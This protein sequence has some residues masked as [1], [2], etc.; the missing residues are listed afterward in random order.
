MAGIGF[1]LRKLTRKGNIGGFVEAYFHA[2]FASSGPW[3]LTILTVWAFFIVG[4]YWRLSEYVEEF[5]VV[6]L[7][8]FSSS[9]V[10]T[11]PVIMLTTRYLADDFFKMDITKV[12]SL[13]IGTLSTQLIVSFPIAFCFYFFYADM[14]LEMSLLA[15]I[16]F[17]LI[18]GIWL[19]MIF[20]S[21]I[22]YYSAITFSFVT[23]MGLGVLLA[24]L[25]SGLF[26]PPGMLFGFNCGLAF[27]LSSFLAVILAEYT[28]N[29][30]NIFDFNHFWKKHWIVALS[31][32][33]YN[34]GIWID[35][36]IMW[37]SPERRVLPNNLIIYP[38]YDMAMF[39]AYLTIIPAMGLFL[40]HQETSFFEVYVRYYR[41]IMQHDPLNK[42]QRSHKDI[43][44]NLMMNGR[45]VLILQ[46]TICVFTLFL[47]PEIMNILG[48]NLVQISVFRF[49]VL[50]VTF[51]IISLFL[52]ITLSYFD[53]KRDVLIIAAT[54]LI[55]N[56][57][58]T[59]LSLN[60][61]FAYYGYGYFM[62]TVLTFIVAAVLSERYISKL[63]YHTFVTRNLAMAS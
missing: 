13:L 27:I 17:L 8:N 14:T 63:T 19:T 41:G 33:C 2:I 5:R 40:I 59:L 25:F 54:F 39:V 29:V 16:N 15:I 35:K 44:D 20:I 21:S 49:G 9:L 42:I 36:W 43:I 11:A 55:S 32:T 31:G 24:Y 12:S 51:Q 6:I 50:G 62:S 3:I 10:L 57:L 47:A 48:M 37:F 58:F 52:M 1:V 22:K 4:D 34:L 23:G 18:S 56:T 45:G 30:K 60:L 46:A 7:Y 53:D 38:E 28:H 26:G 61:G